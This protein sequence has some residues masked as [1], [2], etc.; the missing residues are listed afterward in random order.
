MKQLSTIAA[1]G[2]TVHVNDMSRDPQ[3]IRNLEVMKDFPRFGI[4][5]LGGKPEQA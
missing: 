3:S 2:Q 5:A 1:F 4:Y